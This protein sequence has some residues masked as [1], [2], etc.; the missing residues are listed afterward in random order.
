MK[1]KKK[2]KQP[3]IKGLLKSAYPD[4]HY[5]KSQ[6]TKGIKVELEHTNSKKT[7]K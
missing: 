5:N 1:A 4:S 6:L 2:K 7:A 3:A